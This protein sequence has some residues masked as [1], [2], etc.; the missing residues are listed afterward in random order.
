M[1][2]ISGEERDQRTQPYRGK[3]KDF[4]KQTFNRWIN[5]FKGTKNVVCFT[6]QIIGGSYNATFVVSGY[7]GIITEE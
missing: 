4:S 5:I 7:S 1:V 2:F 6:I 3:Q